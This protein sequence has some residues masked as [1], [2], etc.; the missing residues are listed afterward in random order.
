MLFP[1]MDPYLEEPVL[2]T[3][4]HTA[5]IVYIRNQLQPVLRPRYLT[6]IEERVYV[7]GPAKE[8]VP[9]VWV[10]K[11][12]KAKGAVA[13]LE[14]DK[15]VV[16]RTPARELHEAYLNILDLHDKQRLVTV[17]E[18]LSPTNKYA[19]PGRELYLAKQRE[20]RRSAVHLVE[21]DLLRT[22]PHVLAVAEWAARAQRPYHYLA[23]VNRGSGERDEF[24]LYPRRLAERL[25]RIGIPRAGKD[26][27]VP[28]DV[29]AVV[30]QTYTDGCYQ[31]RIDYNQ[32]CRPPLSPEEQA[33]ANRLLRKA[34]Y[35][36]TTR[37]RR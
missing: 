4:V 37:K 10:K 21:I 18:V 9:D 8:R 12:K 5:L 19:G 11:K 27:D 2:W 23:C 25:P 35:R 7:E 24:D 30:E 13:V 14:A 20:I 16:V 31:D 33:W 22:G 34:G 28:L 6:A 3:G 15:P 17:I 29:Q 32:P 36:P 1:G 26:P